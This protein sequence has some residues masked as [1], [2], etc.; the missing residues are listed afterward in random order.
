M[1]RDIIR[2]KLQEGSELT[3]AGRLIPGTS[4]PPKGGG[5]VRLWISNGIPKRSETQI[6]KTECMGICKSNY[7]IAKGYWELSRSL[8][9]AGTTGSGT[10]EP[11]EV[12]KSLRGS[13]PAYAGFARKASVRS[14]LRDDVF[15]FFS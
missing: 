2:P 8:Q 7:P 13:T 11:S 4:L 15:A 14:T 6:P 1:V 3:L 5:I 9:A 12:R 10:D